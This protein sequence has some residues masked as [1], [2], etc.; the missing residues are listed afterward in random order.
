MLSVQEQGNNVM[1]SSSS[2]IPGKGAPLGE[3][4]NLAQLEN[5]NEDSLMQHLE[6]RFNKDV[7]YSYVGEILV[8]VNPFKTIPGLYSPSQQAKYTLVGNKADLPPHVFSVADIAFQNL[9]Q[10][11]K[12]QTCIISGES[13]AG[14]TEAAKLFVKHLV[15]VSQESE[16]D[17][18]HKQLVEVNP[19]LES[20]GNAQTLRNNNSSRF[21]K[22]TQILMDEKGALKGA[23]ME[24]Y[25]LEKSRVVHQAEG[26]R[27]FHV[28]Y[29][30]FAGL[31]DADKA[32]AH[33]QA[34]DTYN[35]I[36][37]NS[38]A[39][40]EIGT[41]ELRKQA[42]ELMGCFDIVGFSSEE[43]DQL[44]RLVSGV[45]L[46]GNIEFNSDHDA[47]SISN[48]GVLKQC[49]ELLGLETYTFNLALTR[50]INI[51][52]GEETERNYK[53]HE[54]EDCRN[55]TCK[56]V[57]NR[58][59][60][61]IFTR[62]NQLL[63]PKSNARGNKTISILDIFGFECFDS[64]SFEQVCINLANEQLQFFFNEHI[65]RMEM[66]EYASEGLEGLDVTYTDNKPLLDLFLQPSG[67]FISILDE[68]CSFPGATDDSLVMKLH[69][70]FERHNAYTRPRGNAC[71]FTINHFAGPVTYEGDDF[72]YKNRDN[73]AADILGALSDSS[74][75]LVKRLFHVASAAGKMKN[76][77]KRT[78]AQHLKESLRRESIRR[79]RKEIKNTKKQSVALGFKKS[80]ALLMA[81]LNSA[82]P[83]F[84]RCVKPNGSQVGNVFDE[85]MVKKQLRYTGM[86]ETTRIR[87]EGYSYRP[88]FRDFVKR[89]C[90]LSSQGGEGGELPP[91]A[92]SCRIIL[93]AAGIT[94][95]VIGKTKAFLRYYHV[96]VLNNRVREIHLAAIQ[97]QRLARG[98]VSR[99]K[100]KQMRII[101]NKSAL[102]IQKTVRG[103]LSRC[104]TR[105]LLEQKRATM[106]VVAEF[107]AHAQSN[108]AGMRDV[109]LH[110]REQDARR[111]GR[112]TTLPPSSRRKKSALM[113][114]AE[115]DDD[116]EDEENEP[117]PYGTISR[118]ARKEKNERSIR[119]FVTE[120]KKKGAGM[121]EDGF[122]QWFH[123]VISRRESEARLK[124][125]KSGT[126]LV[127]V[128][129]S[130][131]G[132]TLSMVNKG[133]VKHFMINVTD[134]GEY[135]MVGNSRLFVCLNDIVSYHV[136]HSITKVGD[137]LS[138]PCPHNT[139][140][141][142]QLQ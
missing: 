43:Q 72:L 139:E 121:G 118:Q 54:A 49:A 103:F 55:A 119:W 38:D 124:N 39:I 24:V 122:E 60:S 108:G 102:V 112:D 20:F 95:Y 30:M 117:Q 75:G 33:L 105:V 2:L 131:F 68:E 127:R 106:A 1:T 11:G 70:N 82:N 56:A 9:V 110:L 64:N 137:K 23:E 84:I 125:Q 86:L 65:F 4:D 14:K 87:R 83:H 26:E 120:E 111:Q 133:R 135:K 7:I 25:L 52:R 62:C 98:F 77:K 114:D 8:S 91:T 73:L 17:M 47:A 10:G 50:S 48:Q 31:S 37:D 104:R 126:F 61:W 99:H 67:G 115:D 136:A 97:I 22:F 79:A 63:G 85:E 66:A 32:K 21:G 128:A 34:P 129:E 18:L 138:L 74:H 140:N 42:A 80:L 36:N 44:W 78:H 130:R 89:Y 5:L 28:F 3:V 71:E 94:G 6:H 58:L 69:S 88:I 109:I 12:D 41:A 116:D 57:Y 40:H 76:Q 100:T 107:F 16:M 101:K 134:K 141:L 29:L 46:L 15:H 59:F 51:I 35:I 123:G 96:D 132:Y 92:S 90:L 27:N 81:R 142:K 13:G 53:A 45:L 19:L 93:D 113:Y